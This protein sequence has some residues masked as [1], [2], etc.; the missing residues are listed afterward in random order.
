MAKKAKAATG[1]SQGGEKWK[2]V[3]ANK[4]T[5]AKKRREQME[6]SFNQ[7]AKQAPF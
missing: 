4:K 1:E 3:N 6:A 2:Y 7:A 5:S